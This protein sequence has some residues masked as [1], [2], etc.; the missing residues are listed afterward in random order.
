MNKAELK[1]AYEAGKIEMGNLLGE[2]GRIEQAISTNNWYARAGLNNMSEDGRRVL[3]SVNRIIDTIFGYMNNVP[4]PFAAFN[5]RSHTLF[6]NKFFIEQGFKLE[7]TLGKTLNDS[8]PCDANAQAT[9]AAAD[10]AASGKKQTFQAPLTLP[11]GETIIE[12]YVFEPLYN[13]RGQNIGSVLVTADVTHIAKAQEKAQKISAYQDF[14]ALD[15]KRHLD[16]GLSKGILEFVF[17]PEPHDEDTAAA[18]AAYDKIGRTLEYGV[19]F[20]SN[21]VKEIS[22]IL[23]EFARKNF[24][25]TPEQTFRGHFSTIKQSLESVI[26]SVSNLIGEIQSSTMHLESGAGQISEA[27]QKLAATLEEQTA[28]ITQVNEAVTLL[29]EKTQ[30]NA[31][32]AEAASVLS[33]QAQEVADRGRSLME[34]MSNTM[35]QIRQSSNDIAKVADIISQIAFQTN[36]L[37]LNASVEA[38]RAGEHGRGFAVVAEE[39][40]N[41]A[42]RSAKSAQEASDMISVSLSRV[43]EGVA[44]SAQTTQ[45]LKEILAVNSDVTDVIANIANVSG[46]QAD[47]IDKIRQSMDVVH[48]ASTENYMAVQ[49]NA[50]VS[51]ELSTQ[52]VLLQNLV[53]QFRVRK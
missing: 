20:I 44:K 15:I 3:E 34:D 37:A 11:S 1:S 41:L 33:I 35:E 7:G 26:D 45:A 17:K 47:E 13:D 5:E 6:L 50:A 52:A 25:V 43:D 40:R 46:E 42:G 8:W 27:N 32:D 28:S 49:D 21:Y 39:V 38:A 14:E 51:E 4:V 12:E 48:H 16:E 53:E 19:G 18:A 22:G 24:D 10:V 36:L 23:G 29:S 30:K 2:I 9:K 31:Q